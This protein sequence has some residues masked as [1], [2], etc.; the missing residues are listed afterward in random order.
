MLTGRTVLVTGGAS[1]IGRASAIAIAREG[2]RVVVAD[3]Q[4]ATSVVAQIAG[5]GGEAHQH[6]VDV[7]DE[8]AVAA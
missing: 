2:A 7:S 4:D 8:T 5:D 6:Q 1:G 3:L